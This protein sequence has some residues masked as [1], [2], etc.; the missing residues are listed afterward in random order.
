MAMGKL[1]AKYRRKCVGITDKRIR[2]MNEILTCV[3]LIK[4]YAW[5]KSFA[6]AIGSISLSW[7]AS[8][9]NYFDRLLASTPGDDYIAPYE[10]TFKLKS[11][12]RLGCSTHGHCVNR[13]SSPLSTNAH[14]NLPDKM[15][16]SG[17]V[18]PP[19][20]CYSQSN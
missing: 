9:N 1:M 7:I 4:M 19:H 12:E 13:C 20:C 3:K 5:E 17:F 16:I 15:Q 8:L 11:F 10:M 18:L 14:L 6:K 2:M